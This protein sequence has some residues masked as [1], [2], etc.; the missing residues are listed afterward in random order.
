MFQIRIS[1]KTI[2]FFSESWSPVRSRSS[3]TRWRTAGRCGTSRT[4]VPRDGRTT[5]DRWNNFFSDFQFFVLILFSSDILRLFV[6]QYLGVLWLKTRGVDSWVL[7]F[8]GCKKSYHWELL[9]G[10]YCIFLILYQYFLL[11]N[12]LRKILLKKKKLI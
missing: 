8:W 1:F 11:L 2:L 9:F 10:R 6:D 3:S 7:V 5:R 12:S 4:T